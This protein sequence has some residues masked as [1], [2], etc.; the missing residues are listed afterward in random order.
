MSSALPIPD[1]MPADAEPEF[2][3]VPVTNQFDQSQV[4][5]YLRVE[6]SKLPKVPN[7]LFAIGGTVKQA[8]MEWNE[9]LGRQ[10]YTIQEF[11]LEEVALV[12]E[13]QYDWAK[14]GDVWYLERR[15]EVIEQVKAELEA[16]DKPEPAPEKPP[17]KKRVSMKPEL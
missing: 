12:P 11:A 3:E 9:A 4:I 10:V 1:I 7:Y 17:R 2:I 6:K 8:A 14:E 15:P 13:D 16:E 5:G